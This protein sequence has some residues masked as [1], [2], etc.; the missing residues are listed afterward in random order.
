MPKERIIG[1][2]VLLDMNGQF[3]LA[4]DGIIYT[5]FDSKEVK[6]S[7]HIPH[8]ISYSLTLHDR[9]LG[10]TSGSTRIFGLDNA[11]GG[12]FAKNR[13]ISRKIEWDH[14]HKFNRVYDY[15][16]VDCEQL[17]NHYWEN[18]KLILAKHYSIDML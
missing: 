3:P 5:K 2:K 9:E 14:M 18:V 4:N 11:H 10:I 6:P 13:Y 15:T 1:L 16:F 8:G 17:L 7:I 12:K